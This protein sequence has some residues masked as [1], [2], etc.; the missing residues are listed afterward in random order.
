M[1]S[2]PST[3]CPGIPCDDDANVMG[4]CKEFASRVYGILRGNDGGDTVTD[5][6]TDKIS[7]A[8]HAVFL[9][10]SSHTDDQAHQGVPEEGAGATHFPDLDA[11]ARRSIAMLF[12]LRERTSQHAESV[13]GSIFK[14]AIT[15]IARRA[16]AHQMQQQSV[17]GDAITKTNE[18]LVDLLAALIAERDRKSFL[19]AMDALYEKCAQDFETHCIVRILM[20]AYNQ[21]QLNETLEIQLSGRLLHISDHLPNTIHVDGLKIV[22]YNVLADALCVVDQGSVNSHSNLSGLARYPLEIIKMR[23]YSLCAFVHAQFKNEASFVCLQEV[24]VSSFLALRS[25]AKQNE[26]TISE[27]CPKV[28]VQSTRALRLYLRMMNVH[29]VIDDELLGRVVSELDNIDGQ[30]WNDALDTWEW[31]KDL[32]TGYKHFLTRTDAAWG[33]VTIYFPRES[34]ELDSVQHGQFGAVCRSSR[35]DMSQCRSHRRLCMCPDDV[36]ARR[37]GAYRLLL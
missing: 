18:A 31:P 1:G 28:T 8:A 6:I 36:C 4:L 13:R 23:P 37:Y 11:C 24:S 21:V 9:A 3:S 2:T 30:R 15:T 14:D 22:T 29:N 10:H 12:V 34:L 32:P 33:N 35:S 7:A 19:M 5:G 20:C 16:N 25:L 17:R 26:W 27:W